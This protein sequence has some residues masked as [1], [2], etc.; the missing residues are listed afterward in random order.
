MAAG[1][2]IKG[3]EVLLYVG[4]NVVGGQRGASLSMTAK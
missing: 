1:T 2:K 4:E 3:L